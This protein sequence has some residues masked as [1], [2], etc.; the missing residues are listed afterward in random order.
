[1][2]FTFKI[3]INGNNCDNTS[4]KFS[5]GDSS[6]DN[7][8]INAKISEMPMKLKNLDNIISIVD[9]IKSLDKEIQAIE[10]HALL[11][12]NEEMDI[13]I[14]IDFKDGESSIEGRSSEDA[15]SY[16]RSYEK[17][18]MSFF[19]RGVMPKTT[20][21]IEATIGHY[22]LPVEVTL[23]VLGVLLSHKLDRRKNLLNKLKRM[24][25]E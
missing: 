2:V 10:D 5:I 7:Q 1:M 23:Q 18:L 3:T 4:R 20:E 6:K 19:G 22:E 11:V 24:G 13:S 9:E 17:D 14:K 25:I 21:N 15:Y 16:G 8:I 12:A